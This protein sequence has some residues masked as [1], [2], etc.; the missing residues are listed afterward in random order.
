LDD[1]ISL[2]KIPSVVILLSDDPTFNASEA[3]RR[4]VDAVFK[5]PFSM[6][7]LL[8]LIKAASKP[9]LG[10]QLRRA[11]RVDTDFPVS[12][13]KVGAT[14]TL[15]G[16][17]M[18][19]SQG[20]AFVEVHDGSVPAVGDLFEFQITFPGEMAVGGCGRVSWIRL[21]QSGAQRFG[22]GLEFD[23]NSPEIEQIFEAVNRLKTFSR[24]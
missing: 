20:G 21:L 23:R 22:F 11:T 1:L 16:F 6:G 15:A 5:K 18:N 4:G 2:H 13:T 3:F 7:A 8:E 12:L 14:S 10:V 24:G 17:V 9:Y 19:L